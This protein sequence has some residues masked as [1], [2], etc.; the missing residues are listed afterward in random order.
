MTAKLQ[1]LQQQLPRMADLG[2]VSDWRAFWGSAHW[3]HF[4]T[5]ANLLWKQNLAMQVGVHSRNT[6]GLSN[7]FKVVV[8][9]SDKGL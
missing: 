3:S 6:T 9:E 8:V 5:T 2:L 7:S 1:L 4:T